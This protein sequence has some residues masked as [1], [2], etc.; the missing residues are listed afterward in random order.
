[1]K[2]LVIGGHFINLEIDS[3]DIFSILLSTKAIPSTSLS[4]NYLDTSTRREITALT[5]QGTVYVDLASGTVRTPQGEETFHV[6]RDDTY[7]A[8]H[9][10]MINNDDPFICDISEGLRVMRMIDALEEAAKKCV[11][12]HA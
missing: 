7:R 9:I 4:M 12:V 11:W 5:N 1:M 6:E 10:A 2:V 3:D 8:Q